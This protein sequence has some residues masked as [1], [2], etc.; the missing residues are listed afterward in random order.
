MLSLHQWEKHLVFEA[1]GICSSLWSLSSPQALL[2]KTALLLL[3]LR[4]NLAFVPNNLRSSGRWNDSC[5]VLFARWHATLSAQPS[6]DT[7]WLCLSAPGMVDRALF[8]KAHFQVV[9]EVNP[10]N[11]RWVEMDATGIHTH[12]THRLLQCP[13]RFRVAK[14]FT[15]VPEDYG[16]FRGLYLLRQLFTVLADFQQTIILPLGFGVYGWYTRLLACFLC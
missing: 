16:L 12:S 2:L 13:Q 5:F 15:H 8:R 14:C 11:Y 4:R 6:S 3:A 1:W 7:L 9:V 10:T